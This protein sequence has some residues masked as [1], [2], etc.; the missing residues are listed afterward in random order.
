MSQLS[1]DGI[2]AFYQRNLNSGN[3]QVTSSAAGEIHF[4][5][6]NGKRTT[7]S[8][9]LNI[10]VSRERTEVTIDALG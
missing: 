9:T 4:R 10:A 6:T 3:W 8:G 7:A 1:P 2:S 5:L